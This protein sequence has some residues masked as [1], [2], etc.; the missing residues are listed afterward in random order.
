MVTK[1]TTA[2]KSTQRRTK[3]FA[4]AVL[5]KPSGQILE[6]VKQAGLE[7]FGIVGVDCAKDRSKW[8]LA[9]F[10]ERVLIPPASVTS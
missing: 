1:V 9:D 5:G 8:M 4:A 7:H 10:Y 6:R 2:K 3:A